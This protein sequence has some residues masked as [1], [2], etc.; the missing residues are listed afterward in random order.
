[1]TYIFDHLP[2]A[3]TIVVVVFCSYFALPSLAA[4][5]QNSNYELS[6]SFVPEEGRLIGTS[7]I[8]IKK[9]EKLT[10]SLYGLE[11]T[12]SLLQDENGREHELLPP[13]DVLILPAAETRRTLYLSYTRSIDKDFDNLISPNGIS[14]SS[15][16]YPL[17]QQPMRFQVTAILPDH[18]SAVMEADS[19]PLQQQGNT[20]SATFSKPVTN[21]HFNAG[22]YSMKKQRV[23]E[24]LV[25]YTMFFKEDAELADGYLQAAADF[26]RRYE[27]EIGS[28]PYNHY[29]IV[30]NRLPTGY[31]MP[32]FTLLGQMVLR[33]PFI[34]ETSLG[35]EIVH[36][37]FGNGVEV[38]SSEG[39]WCEGLTAFLADHAFREEKGE[40]VADRLESITRY[41][42][43]VHKESAIPLAAFTSASHNQPMAEA[44][45]AVGYNRGALLFY[46]LREKIG[47]KAFADGIRLFYADYNGKQA[48]WS[49][50]QKSFTITSGGDLDSFFTE[51][52]TRSEIAELGVEE[53]KI[54][55]ARNSPILSFTLVQQ[56]AEPFSLVVPIRIET[57]SSTIEVNK[58]ITEKKNHISIPLDQVPLA[59]T[60]DP[61]HAFLRQLTVKE[62]PPVWS[63]F[64]GAEKKLV[65][66]GKESDRDLYQPFL[67]TLDEKGL[68]ITTAAEV[69]NLELSEHDLLFLGPDQAPARGLFGRADHAEEGFTV[70]VR[71]HPLNPNHVAVLVSS[72]AK[73]QTAAL[74]RRI[75]HYGKYSYLTFKNGRNVTKRIEPTSSGLRFVLEELPAGGATS[76]LAPFA[77]IVEK[78]AAAR[79]VYVGE[80]HTSLADHLLQ[81]R[82]IE[83]LHRKNPKIAI[84]MEMFPASSQAAL[85]KYTLSGEEVDERTFLK[86]SDYYN[87][88]R[89]D[90]RYFRD[91]INFARKNR[92]PVIG[93]NLDRQIVSE[94][95]RSGGTDTLSQE[96]QEDLPRDRNLDMPGYGE[97]LSFMHSV[98]MQGSH[99]SG[100][101]SGFIQAQGLWDETMAENI[102]AFLTSHP[103]Y[104]MVVLAGSQ[105]TRKDSGIPP[106][107]LRRLPVEQASVL[108]IINESAPTDL[109]A[110]ADYY[111]LAAP[112]ELAEAP[113]IGI[114]LDT[115]KADGRSFLKISR[116]SPHG[117]AAAAGLL[118]G[119]VL[120]QV[121]GY[122][123]SD[124][125]DLRIAMLDAKAGET[126][127]IKV[128]RSKG[129]EGV[130]LLY[131]VELTLP[132]APLP[133]P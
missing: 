54:D 40:G 17:P 61:D 79:V 81:L 39:N 65:I 99:G 116:L 6:L 129:D 53:I 112:A 70:D 131:K 38:D 94:V 98:H 3:I 27:K 47:K 23:R 46:E 19:F 110:V 1:M 31:G 107:V 43:Y 24:G 34:K 51:R 26:L 36:S 29:V 82:I 88:W 18:F 44:R 108:N 113:K 115:E 15:N 25:V 67:D 119:D 30:A 4:A 55:H 74:A 77:R 127:D 132:P 20:V 22:P 90:Y 71:R 105:H 78:L 60:V 126:V 76:A 42:S 58:A 59:F 96:V 66:L 33:L 130:E 87:V 64:M 49:D 57:M 45:R 100:A 13:G 10:L 85:D 86:E 62:L 69:S 111:F 101:V 133:Q 16:W 117:K 103:E 89:F 114:V 97:R 68:R 80:T 104:Q 122:P 106:R 21:I 84:G 125:A 75:G 32:T 28:Y 120:Q 41:L 109:A 83:A 7:K 37:W 63:R 91:I 118:A 128:V 93:L 123:V 121:N 14:L 5:V 124:M 73:E 72:S 48:D 50:L 8:T 12:G 35:H 95:F 52:L 9:G 2:T 11:V 92:L 56:S 102:V